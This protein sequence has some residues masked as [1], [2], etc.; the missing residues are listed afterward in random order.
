MKDPFFPLPIPVVGFLSLFLKWA[1][2][3]RLAN[4]WSDD[5]GKPAV[6]T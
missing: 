4:I 5:Y 2:A 3:A 6:K 1:V